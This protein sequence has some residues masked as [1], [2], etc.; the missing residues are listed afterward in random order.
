[1]TTTPGRPATQPSPDW[2]PRTRRKG[3][4]VTFVSEDGT[5][6]KKFDFG[7]LPGNPAL[8]R[9]LAI[10]FDEVTGPLGT[11]KRLSG[12][13]NV[14]QAARQAAVWF[15][16]NRPSL[17]SLE[18]LTS[19]DAQMLALAFRVPSGGGLTAT[20]KTLLRASPL[21]SDDVRDA[22][23]RL[24]LTKNVS[25]RQ[26]YSERELQRIT[27]AARGLVRRARARLYANWG[28]VEDYRAGLFDDLPVR[29]PTRSLGHALDYCA[30]NGDFP[31]SASGTQAMVTRRAVI[32]ANGRPLLSL[33]HL[34]AGEAWAFGVLIAAYAGLNRSVIAEL[35][36]PHAYASAPGEPGILFV[37]T[38]KPRRGA[39]SVMT[40]PLAALPTELHP[41]QQ[42]AEHPRARVL[43]T[44]LNTAYGVFR[45]LVELTEPTRAVMGCERAFAFYNAKPDSAHQGVF[46][47]GLSRNYLAGPGRR[48]L[49][50][51]W[52]TGEPT[53]DDLL[54]NILLDRLRKSYLERVRKPVSHTPA[55][56]ARYLSRMDTV[57]QEGFQIVREA[58]DDQV[59]HARARMAI[60]VIPTENPAA[61]EDSA[62]QDT[63]LAECADFSHSPIDGD[64]CRQSFMTC[65]DC[66]NARAFPRHLP[67]QLLVLDRL[68][69]EHGRLPI[70]QW[71]A[72]YAG[73]AAQLEDIL[74]EYQPSQINEARD[75]VT[76]EHRRTVELFF[77]GGL[78]AS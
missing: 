70:Q 35:P 68:R 38:N 78:E 2:R 3:L 33:L 17:T 5:Q 16:G 41:Q 22:L 49:L 66:A 75:A 15:S 18:G 11:S 26:P 73:R 31:R 64:T 10:A 27:T 13:A 37:E 42:D 55:T 43:N 61:E 62:A 48:T 32:A 76:A 21:I 40:M 9:E 19:A 50:K 44:S 39:R 57:T 24:R 72:E 77:A 34:S 36:A 12:A 52:M 67:V 4:V 23:S 47:V 60:T 30:R 74:A 1:M 7:T 58:L 14:F 56:L 63:V 53:H 69:L 45:L 6:T 8:L 20:L 25:A 28:M 54:A 59:L 51:P 46:G 29:D 71:V 65:L